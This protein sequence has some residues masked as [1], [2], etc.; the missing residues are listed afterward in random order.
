[1]LLRELLPEQKSRLRLAIIGSGPLFSKI[2]TKIKDAGIANVVWLPGA[3][4][5]VA[6][7]MHSFSVFAMTSIA[8]GTPV[9][10]LEAMASGLPIIA[11]NVGGIPEVVIDGQTGKLVSSADT[12]AFAKAL[13][14]YIVATDTLAEHGAAGRK[15]AED[16]YSV[17]AMLAAYM[18]LYDKLC[19][20][21]SII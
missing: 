6:N 13:S 20:A 14:T 19:V 8:E 12:T 4:D 9:V 10:I 18:G 15:R 16:I 3:R 5:D 2:E 7:L 21:K 11:T 1:M 17:E